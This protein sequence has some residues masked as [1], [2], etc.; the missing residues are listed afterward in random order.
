[1]PTKPKYNYDIDK[2]E[3][4]ENQGLSV[5]AISRKFGWPPPNTQQWIKRNF[6]KTV[7]YVGIDKNH[8]DEDDVPSSADS[9]TDNSIGPEIIATIV[10]L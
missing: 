7:K 8:N 3:S 5:R 2:I 10:S 9:D 1:M 6:K 4:L